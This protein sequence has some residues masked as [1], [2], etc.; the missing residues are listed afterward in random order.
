MT[1][2][3]LLTL[4]CTGTDTGTTGE[5]DSGTEAYVAPPPEFP[6]YSGEGDC[7]TFEEGINSGFDSAGQQ[8]KFHLFLPDEPAGAPLIFNFHPLGWEAEDWVDYMDLEQWAK[9]SGAIVVVPSSCC[10]L[11]E[12]MFLNPV[13]DNEDLAFFDDSI[14]C[15]WNQFEYDHNRIYSTGMSAGGLFTTYLTLHRAEWLA[16]TA[17]FS[18]GTEGFFNYATP[19]DT[20]P[21]LVTWGGPTDSWNGYDFNVANQ[22]FSQSLQDDGHFVAECMHTGGHTMSPSWFDWAFTWMDAHPKGVDPSPLAGG[23][24]DDFPSWCEIPE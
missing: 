11:L 24:T 5:T 18:G 22:S 4:A 7:P 10:S 13:E 21:V 19:A 12:W 1:P 15:L 20:I 23:L 8:R 3:L 2:F 17:P 9:D 16:A 14:G 6:V